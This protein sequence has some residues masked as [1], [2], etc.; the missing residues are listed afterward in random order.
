MDVSGIAAV[1]T[2]MSQ[3]QISDSVQTAVLKKAMDIE[4]LTAQQ[5]VQVLEQSV[6]RNPPHLGNNIDVQA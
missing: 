3:V 6:P 1:A 5:M 2:Q 4:K